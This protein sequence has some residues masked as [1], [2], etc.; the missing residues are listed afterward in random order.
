MKL[1]S[2][3][4]ESFA[5]RNRMISVL[6]IVIISI[7]SLNGQEIKKVTEMILAMQ[8]GN[9]SQALELAKSIRR[10]NYLDKDG[11]S[12]LM[13]SSKNGCIEVVSLL[14]RKKAGVNLKAHNGETALMKASAMGHKEV[15]KLLLEYGAEVD[16]RTI[17][18]QT[19][20]YFASSYGKI[21]VAQM[22]LEKGANA[23]LQTALGYTA[24]MQAVWYKQTELVKLLLEKGADVNLKTID[25][26]TALHVGLSSN[27]VM[28]NYDPEIIANNMLDSIMIDRT[29][30]IVKM[31]LENGAKVNLQDEIGETALMTAAEFGNTEAV[32]LLLER[33]ANREIKSNKGMT[34]YD[35]AKNDDIKTLLSK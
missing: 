28:M 11:Q 3:Y 22:L 16:Y 21:E 32:K 23:N 10:V 27:A 29:E 1:R 8:D 7:T 12:D 30:E 4:Q 5:V 31:L 15:V 33:G 6:A 13:Y 19:A 9:C 17:Y 20:L 18:G 34:A 26:E 14:L 24:L 25:G 2:I 35:Y